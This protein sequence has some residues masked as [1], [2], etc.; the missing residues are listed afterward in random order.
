MLVDEHASVS[1]EEFGRKEKWRNLYCVH[2][3]DCS[4]SI[5]NNTELGSRG[6]PGEGKNEEE[7]KGKLICAGIFDK[8]PIICVFVINS[9]HAPEAQPHIIGHLQMEKGKEDVRRRKKKKKKDQDSEANN[10]INSSANIYSSF[11]IFLV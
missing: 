4:H 8:K 3:T 1:A 11:L 5:P 9:H 6:A 10:V 2:T 7:T